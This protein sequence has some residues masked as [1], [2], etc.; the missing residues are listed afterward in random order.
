M[1]WSARS[2]ISLRMLPAMSQAIASSSTEALARGS[3]KYESQR[4]LR[5]R[6]PQVGCYG[7]R[8]LALGSRVAIYCGDLG[9]TQLPRVRDGGFCCRLL[10]CHFGVTC[11]CPNGSFHAS[12]RSRHPRDF[13]ADRVLGEVG[14]SAHL[15]VGSMARTRGMWSSVRLEGSRPLGERNRRI[16]RGAGFAFCLDLRAVFPSWSTKRRCSA[17]RREF[18]LDLRRHAILPLGCCEHQEQRWPS[19][20]TRHIG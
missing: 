16:R 1:K 18:Q 12:S 20:S 19:E 5:V 9:Y 15:G 8:V 2:S 6:T 14:A 10:S 3:G 17:A 11:R 7:T 4:F 13:G